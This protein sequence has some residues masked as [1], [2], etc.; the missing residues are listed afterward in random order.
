MRFLAATFAVLLFA[1]AAFAQEPA[2]GPVAPG[3]PV[4]GEK[5]EA[6]WNNSWYE[7]D[8]LKVEG[9]KFFVHWRGYGAESDEWLTRDRLRRTGEEKEVLPRKGREG[10]GGGLPPE[11]MVGKNVEVFWHGKWWP[12]RVEKTDGKRFFIHYLTGTGTMEEWAVRERVRE[13][14]GA[15]KIQIDPAKVPGKKGLSGLFWRQMG[16]PGQYYYQHFLF[17]PDGRLY[18][19]LPDNPDDFDFEGHRKTNPGECGGYGI[20]NGQL[21]VELGGDADEWAPSTFEQVSDDRIKI[22]GVSALRARPMPEDLRLE[23][24]YVSMNAGSIG[25]MDPGGVATS[26]SDTYV[27]RKDGTYDYLETLFI[28]VD[29]ADAHGERTNMVTGKYYF[30]GNHLTNDSPPDHQVVVAYPMGPD[31]APY[32]ILR[33]GDQIVR[34]RKK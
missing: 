30:S 1:P 8:I 7:V 29:K 3:D 12:A 24:R 32:D 23:G 4:V 26:S 10:D 16:A 15:V 9:G 18:F 31:D 11:Q 33:I 13:V 22:N 21:L 5:C 34:L 20:E 25:G 28:S 2:T 27:F 17:F 14:G 19:G 6:S